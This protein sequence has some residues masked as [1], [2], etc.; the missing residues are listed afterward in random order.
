MHFVSLFLS[1]VSKTVPWLLRTFAQ[2]A[3]SSPFCHGYQHSS[4][5]LSQ[6]PRY[7]HFLFVCILDLFLIRR[8]VVGVTLSI[9]IIT[10]NT[11]IKYSCFSPLRHLTPDYWLFGLPT[12]LKDNWGSRV[13]CCY[14]YS[15]FIFQ[16]C[17]TSTTCFTPSKATKILLLSP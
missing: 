1:P 8:S 2:Q 7:N 6:T 16:L 9:L 11:R 14:V 13:G 10:H 12:C 4:K 15:A 3:P 17:E 5:T